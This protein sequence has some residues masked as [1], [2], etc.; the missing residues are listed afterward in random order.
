MYSN[1]GGFYLNGSSS[2][3]QMK[4]VVSPSNANQSVTWSSGNTGIVKISSS[5]YA[6]PVSNGTTTITARTVNGKTASASVTVINCVTIGP[7]D[8]KGSFTGTAEI[9][10]FN[11]KNFY[12]F[13][14]KDEE[15]GSYPYLKGTIGGKYQDTNIYHS[16][17]HL[18]SLVNGTYWLTGKFIS[19]KWLAKRAID[20]GYRTNG[21]IDMKGLYKDISDNCGSKY[22]IEYVTC[23][24]SFSSLKKYLE[25]GYV[26]LGGGNGHVMAFV[27][28]SGDKFL[29]LD[30]YYTYN[31]RSYVWKTQNQMTGRFNC[32][33]FYIIKRR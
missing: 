20:K 15:W 28:Y 1:N 13:S 30:S 29:V 26:G 23:I 2:S 33:Y 12:V 10:I 14:Q 4:A 18:L 9:G 8:Y 5:G 11:W 24:S 7:S 16:G 6:T 3:A 22:G 21:D 31:G 27:A 32:S 17:C 25:K 19:P